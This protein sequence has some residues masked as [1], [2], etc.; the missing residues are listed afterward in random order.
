MTRPTRHAPVSRFDR[1]Y[2][3]IKR[4]STEKISKCKKNDRNVGVCCCFLAPVITPEDLQTGVTYRSCHG[5]RWRWR[6][7]WWRWWWWWWWWLRFT[8]SN[9]TPIPSLNNRSF[10]I[11]F[12]HHYSN[13][14]I[15]N[16][17][18]KSS[19]NLYIK[20]QSNIFIERLFI[21]S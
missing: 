13:V 1:I 10:D 19:I 2:K 9:F 18:S 8:T 11:A 14:K 6:W 5:D 3:S 15:P 12:R 21:N 17:Y 4:R 7:S 16:R 20:I